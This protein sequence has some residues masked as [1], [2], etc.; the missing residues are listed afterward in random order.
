MTENEFYLTRSFADAVVEAEK[1]IAEAPHIRTEQDL[2]EGY[3]YLA[4]LGAPLH[5][6]CAV[7]WLIRPDLFTARA[8]SVAAS[9]ASWVRPSVDSW[10]PSP[11][12][13]RT[14]SW[15]WSAR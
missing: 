11:A 2:L 3:D 15:P 9:R 14:C 6:P 5:D 13:S 4:G 1:L 7:A 12:R 8:C 10:S